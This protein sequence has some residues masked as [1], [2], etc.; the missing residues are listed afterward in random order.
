[1][2]QLLRKLY[3]YLPVQ[4]RFLLRRL[5]FLPVDFLTYKKRKH[6]MIPPI[7]KLFIG[8]G[9]FVLTGNRFAERLKQYANLHAESKVLDIGCGIGRLARPL[10]QII[11]PSG[12]YCGFDVVKT[13]IIWCNKNISSRYPHFEFKHVHLSNDL[14]NKGGQNADEFTF[15]YNVGSFTIVAAISVYTHLLPHET[16]RYLAETSRVL[17]RGGIAFCTFFI[18]EENKKLPPKFNFP[19]KYADYSL[20]NEKVSRAN[21][22][23]NQLFL[24][25]MIE[26]NGFELKQWLKGQWNTPTGIDLQDALVL[27]KK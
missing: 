27:V 4:L 14:Y 20:M 11:K 6:N 17:E 9:D 22:L 23:Y 24:F 18:H 21:V 8:S 12:N 25:D 13:G 16:N 3:Y 5:I 26:Q 1:M 7:G 15:P 19:I 10:T 2:R